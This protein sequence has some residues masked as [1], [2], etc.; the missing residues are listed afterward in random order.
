MGQPVTRIL[1]TSIQSSC[2]HCSLSNLCLPI[3]VKEEDLGSLE[4]FVQQ[5]RSYDRGETIFSQNNP[6]RSC[7]AVRSGSV[8]TTLMSTS[9][10]EQVTGFFLPGEIIGL[11]SL[12]NDA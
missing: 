9:G 7:Y 8:K 1:A 12:S 2:Q 10:E 3:A 6:A 4:A 5:G 11:D